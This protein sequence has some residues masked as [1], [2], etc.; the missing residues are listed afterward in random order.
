MA[1]KDSSM[2]D[3]VKAV[4]SNPVV[5]KSL[6]L[7]VVKRKLST[8]PGRESNPGHWINKQTLYHVAV[9]A[10]FYRKAVEVYFYI[11]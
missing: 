11:P 8:C 2:D 5:T 3:K 10:C 7:I 6:Q 9:K 1:S 4:S